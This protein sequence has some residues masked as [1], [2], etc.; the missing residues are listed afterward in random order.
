MICIIISLKKLFTNIV[1]K[2]HKKYLYICIYIIYNLYV[3]YN[4]LIYIQ[5]MFSIN[6]EFTLT[7]HV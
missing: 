2:L 3:I 5:I 6:N 4:V 1:N 7:V